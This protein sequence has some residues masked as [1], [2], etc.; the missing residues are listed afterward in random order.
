MIFEK[1][2]EFF[3]IIGIML[4]G[5]AIGKLIEYLIKRGKDVGEKSR[6]NNLDK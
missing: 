1:I 6:Q 3:A 2:T 4:F 5:Y